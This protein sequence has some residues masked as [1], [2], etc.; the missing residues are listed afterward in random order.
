MIGY[1][2]VIILAR[3]VPPPGD[4]RM[5]GFLPV[6]PP[7]LPPAITCIMNVMFAIIA[8]TLILVGARLWNKYL[9]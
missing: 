6:L 9:S 7:V 8:L 4:A 5:V 1:M 3:S 2:S